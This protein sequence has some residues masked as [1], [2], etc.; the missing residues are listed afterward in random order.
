MPV[1]DWTRV[2][3]GTFHD[4]RATWIIDLKR[5]LNEG[6]LPPDYYA[7]AEQI[8]GN[9]GPDVLTLEAPPPETDATPS[10]G[11][12]GIATAPAPP[13]VRFTEETEEDLYA[14]KRR[15]LVI[16]HSSEDRVV[17]LLEILSPG[18]KAS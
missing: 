17:A 6:L 15:S 9:V 3:A 7:M 4:F 10:D 13:K 16:R 14:R 18:N 8:A 12:G 11:G 5:A 2:G 1:H